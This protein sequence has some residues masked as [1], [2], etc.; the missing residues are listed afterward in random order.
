[1]NTLNQYDFICVV[2]ENIA[3]TPTNG[4]SDKDVDRI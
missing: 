2:D 3:T 1:M 4:M